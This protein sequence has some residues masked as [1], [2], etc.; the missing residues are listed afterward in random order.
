MFLT[1]F[2][3]LLQYLLLHLF[4]FLPKDQQRSNKW[5]HINRLFTTITMSLKDP[6]LTI[7]WHS[8]FDALLPS[9][10]SFSTASGHPAPAQIKIPVQKLAAGEDILKENIQPIQNTIISATIIKLTR[11]HLFASS[12]TYGSA[13]C[14]LQCNFLKKKSTTSTKPH[15]K[16][17]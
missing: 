3:L 6:N 8:S 10:Y 2:L 7:S 11:I 1:G 17:R 5:E 9:W 4:P 16:R 13:P 12:P 14:M 15:K